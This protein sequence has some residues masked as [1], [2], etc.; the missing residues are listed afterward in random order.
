[1]VKQRDSATTAWAQGRQKRRTAQTLRS[2]Y[3]AR[4][5]QEVE[6]KERGGEEVEERFTAVL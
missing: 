3:T 6:G 1:M 5:T 2:N 4:L